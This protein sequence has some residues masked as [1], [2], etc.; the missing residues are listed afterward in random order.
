MEGEGKQRERRHG[1]GEVGMEAEPDGRAGRCSRKREQG[2]EMHFKQLSIQN[3]TTYQIFGRELSFTQLAPI[4]FYGLF[5]C[6]E[7]PPYTAHVA[8]PLGLH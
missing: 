3:K 2:L 8:T 6:P 1:E 5:S 4:C 7:V